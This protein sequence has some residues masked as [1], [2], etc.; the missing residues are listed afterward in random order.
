VEAGTYTSE[1]AVPVPSTPNLLPYENFTESFT[2]E[3]TAGGPYLE[4]VDIGENLLTTIS[5]TW[6]VWLVFTAGGRVSNRI[7]ITVDK[8]H[9]KDSSTVI[10][11]E[12]G[13]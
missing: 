7:V 13:E 3:L 4:L 5:K 8:N 6:Q 11:P 9:I 10:D 1:D 2:P 12:W